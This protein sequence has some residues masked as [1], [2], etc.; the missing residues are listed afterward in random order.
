LR[1]IK[2]EFSFSGKTV[3]GLKEL[4]IYSDLNKIFGEFERRIK[5]WD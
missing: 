4:E 1:P 2:A 3:F 5:N